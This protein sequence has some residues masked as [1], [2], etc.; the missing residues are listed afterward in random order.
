VA[1]AALTLASGLI[2]GGGTFRQILQP[3]AALI[4]L[5][6]TFGAVLIQF[7]WRVVRQAL[8]GLRETVFGAKARRGGLLSLES[9][10][11]EIEDPFSRRCL[12]LAIDGTPVHTLRG[13][14]ELELDRMDE[15][16]E[17][18]V[19]VWEA[20]A[21][22]SPTMGILGAVL[23]LIQVMQQ[24]DDIS[25]VGKGI[26]VA[27]V[28]TLYGVGA[29][30]LL[31]LPVAG[32]LRSRVRARQQEREMTLDAACLL[33]EGANPRTLRERLDAHMGY[34]LGPASPGP[35]ARLVVR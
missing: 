34:G 8:L 7:P 16:S 30:N 9:E 18:A 28:A 23:G 4:V 6:G 25:S 2:V 29:A 21:G 31:F 12:M 33:V 32:K 27:F 26:A 14:M 3:T 11:H 17:Q 1:V 13:G 35:V 22:F 15:R 10:L 20:A 19:K 24:L 5:G